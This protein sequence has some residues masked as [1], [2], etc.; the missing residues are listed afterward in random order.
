MLTSLV[1][2]GLYF[3]GNRKNSPQRPA[4]SKLSRKSC[5][6]GGSSFLLR[7]CRGRTTWCQRFRLGKNCMQRVLSS[8]RKDVQESRCWRGESEWRRGY[9][10]LLKWSKVNMFANRMKTPSSQCL[11]SHCRLTSVCTLSDDVSSDL[12]NASET[13]FIL[14][15]IGG[16]V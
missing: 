8:W 4:A 10:S 5:F 12:L 7:F 13:K 11:L 1:D 9:A 2:H 3:H 15:N 14:E 16:Q 6:Y